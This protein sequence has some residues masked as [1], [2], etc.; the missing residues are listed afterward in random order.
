MT[1]YQILGVEKDASADEIKRAYRKLAKEHHPDATN[2]NDDQIKAINQAYEVLSDDERRARYDATGEYLNP[3]D[4]RMIIL[5]EI[6]D[7]ILGFLGQGVS[8]N[9]VL[10]CVRSKIEHN[11]SNINN[12]IKSTKRAVEK[13]NRLSEKIRCNH[14]NNLL[15]A[16]LENAANIAGD[17]M[18]EFE[19]RLQ[20]CDEQLKMLNEYSMEQEPLPMNALPFYVCSTT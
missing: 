2:G 10:S 18:K 14:D 15:K 5:R 20:H 13:L 11:R 8:E 19:A 1:L 16:Y 7:G 3:K 6:G 9:Q 4:M 12:E 17:S